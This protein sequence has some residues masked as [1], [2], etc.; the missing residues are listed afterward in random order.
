MNINPFKE[1]MIKLSINKDTFYRLQALSEKGFGSEFK[2]YQDHAVIE[3]SR[4]V[5]QHLLDM[6]KENESMDGVIVRGIQD[7]LGLMGKENKDG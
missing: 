5:L 3:V 4:D 7:Y 1:S 2:V 6:M